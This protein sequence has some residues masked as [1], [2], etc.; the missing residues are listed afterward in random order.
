MVGKGECC[1]LVKRRADVASINKVIWLRVK[2]EPRKRLCR[3]TSCLG[4]L[5]HCDLCLSGPA[6]RPTRGVAGPSVV[7]NRERPGTCDTRLQAEKGASVRIRLF[8]R[9]LPDLISRPL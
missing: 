3:P 6:L 7:R 2:M 9:I 8:P 5:L 4:T 1:L